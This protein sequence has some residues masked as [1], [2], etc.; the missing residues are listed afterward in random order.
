MMNA[1]INPASPYWFDYFWIHVI[2]TI[3]WNVNKKIK[4]QTVRVLIYLIPTAGLITLLFVR[5]RYTGI[6]LVF[7]CIRFPINIID[8]NFLENTIKKNKT[9]YL[10]ITMTLAA[11]MFFEAN[12][13]CIYARI[14]SPELI[15]LPALIDPLDILYILSIIINLCLATWRIISRGMFAIICGQF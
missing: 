6:A 12:Y 14:K 11:M 10:R 13:I 7:R 2:T 1:R 4:R 8:Y 9:S 15:Y 3:N 5:T